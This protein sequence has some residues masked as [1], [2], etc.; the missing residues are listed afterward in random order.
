MGKI[1]VTADLVINYKVFSHRLVCK[2]KHDL[3]FMASESEVCTIICLMICVIYGLIWLF[4]AIPEIWRYIE[5]NNTTVT[6]DNI[7][8]TPKYHQ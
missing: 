7:T 8:I 5:G 2:C 1:Q 6:T 4:C 3:R